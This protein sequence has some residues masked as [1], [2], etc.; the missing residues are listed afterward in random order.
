MAKKNCARLRDPTS[1][2]R[3]ISHN[4]QTFLAI[5]VQIVSSEVQNKRLQLLSSHFAQRAESENHN[6]EA[7]D[8][9]DL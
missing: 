1:G 8:I 3:A 6:S 5:S 7:K 9:S 4:L 2:R